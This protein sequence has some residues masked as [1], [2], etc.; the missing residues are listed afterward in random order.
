MATSILEEYKEKMTD[1]QRDKAHGIPAMHKPLLL[2]TVIELIENEHIQENKIIYSPILRKTFKN[3]WTIVKRG[4]CNDV[5]PFYHLTGDGFWHLQPNVRQ[6][7]KLEAVRQIKTITDLTEI[8][9]YASLD[10]PLFELLNEPQS[11]EIIRQALIDKYFCKFKEKIKNLI[12]EQRKFRRKQIEEY[13]ALIEDTTHPFS[14][15]HSPKKI[16]SVQ[17]KKIVRDASFRQKIMKIYDHTCAVCRLHILTKNGKSITDA[18]HIVPF[19]ESYNDDVRNGISLCKSHHWIFDQRLIS[20]SEDYEVIISPS[21]SEQERTEW[22]LAE[23]EGKCIRL[24]EEDRLHP[25]QEALAWHRERL[26]RR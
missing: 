23:L 9:A 3:Y 22:T 13:S 19:S 26:F 18:A 10:E 2:L 24:P 21:V 14:L 11:Q 4:S 5:L 12:E 15:Y 25:A 8:V 6:K 16:V 17:T 7:T 20:V 1:L